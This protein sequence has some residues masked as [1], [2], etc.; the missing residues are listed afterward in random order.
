MKSQVIETEEN[1]EELT[2]MEIEERN[3]MMTG[4]LEPILMKLER[5][6]QDSKA[7]IFKYNEMRDLRLKVNS[8]KVQSKL[9]YGPKNAKKKSIIDSSQVIGALF[10]QKFIKKRQEKKKQGKTVKQEPK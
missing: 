9:D 3:D 10:L 5:K 4:L 2:E 8:K 6:G 1:E 7:S